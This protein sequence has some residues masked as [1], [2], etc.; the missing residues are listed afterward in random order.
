M[1]DCTDYLVSIDRHIVSEEALDCIS[2][3][4]QQQGTPI[5]AEGTNILC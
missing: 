4:W 2:L 3:L 5:A 1:A